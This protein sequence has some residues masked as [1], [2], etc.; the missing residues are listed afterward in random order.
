ML[1][2]RRDPVLDTN[3]LPSEEPV[4]TI[5][6]QLSSSVDRS[7]CSSLPMTSTNL[8]SSRRQLII[9]FDHDHHERYSTHINTQQHDF[10]S[11]MPSTSIPLIGPK[12][13]GRTL[14]RQKRLR[15]LPNT[16]GSDDGSSEPI[17]ISLTLHSS[18]SRNFTPR[19]PKLSTIPISG[20]TN[21]HVRRDSEPES[22]ISSSTSTTCPPSKLLQEATPFPA[23]GPNS[24]P[25]R[26]G[27]P[28]RPYYSAIRKQGISPPPSR[29]SS[30]LGPP[31]PT[32]VRPQSYNPPTSSPS[33]SS[34]AARH[35]SMSAMSTGVYSVFALNDTDSDRDEDE[36]HLPMMPLTPS[37]V[38][39]RMSFSLSLSNA[40]KRLSKR[41]SAQGPSLITT[42]QRS[43]Y[44]HQYS[45]S[46]SYP[47]AQH[48]DSPSP[49]ILPP[50]LSQT[51]TKPKGYK[52]GSSRPTSSS[53]SAGIGFSMSGET[54]LRMA[55]AMAD[56]E[57]ALPSATAM[58]AGVAEDGFRFHETIASPPPPS[59][60]IPPPMSAGVL[61]TT[62]PASGPGGMDPAAKNS[63]M[64]RVKKLRKGLK[65]MLL[66]NTNA[67]N[68]TTSN[69]TAIYT[70]S[71]A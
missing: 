21:S 31:P 45:Q 32:S 34:S 19:S 25:V 13:E 50:A 46:I 57:T 47:Y 3:S 26:V 24:S 66:M 53:S 61:N 5:Q 35:L 27:H 40:T 65:N 55:L 20:Q 6:R 69:T 48:V 23:P 22:I 4:P 9:D 12:A 14:R 52:V 38:P 49:S 42:P 43:S 51:N 63:F 68:I 1:I 30:V 15:V 18:N 10:T 59:S 64:R 44:T 7:T 54:E 17:A 37:P 11:S 56:R 62:A 70:P 36:D 28:S 16:L 8:K 60:Y 41:K 39:E 71:A 29:P 2:R 58:S 33:H 67:T